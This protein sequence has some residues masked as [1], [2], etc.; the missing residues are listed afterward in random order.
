MLM[1]ALITALAGMAIPVLTVATGSH[2][3]MAMIA[4]AMALRQL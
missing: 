2:R 1:N 3:L 4:I